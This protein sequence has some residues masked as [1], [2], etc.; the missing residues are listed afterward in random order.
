M[1]A[2]RTSFFLLMAILMLALNLIGFHQSYFLQLL[3]LETSMSPV[4]HIHVALGFTLFILFIAQSYLAWKNRFAT[5]KK[6]GPV[7]AIVA[8]LLLIAGIGMIREVASG[9]IADPTEDQLG[10]MMIKASAVW[11]S[12]YVEACFALFMGLAI[13]LRGNGDYHKR[14]IF[15]A[16][17][18][19]TSPALS[20]M[21]QFPVMGLS[22]AAFTLGSM[23]LLVIALAIYDLRSRKRVH[24]VTVVGGVVQIV[25]LGICAA[26]LPYTPFGERVIL[27]L[28]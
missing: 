28:G 20:R 12:I 19:I 23:L 7:A 27:M 16:L 21:S 11:V 24:W 22:P 3:N 4:M 18:G 8:L 10:P 13:F 17:V 2:T 15:L 1:P 25:G 5:H 9:Y 14:L 26:V 6:L